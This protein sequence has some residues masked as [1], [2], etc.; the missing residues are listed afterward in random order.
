MALPGEDLL[1]DAIDMHNHPL[2]EG[3][4]AVPLLYETALGMKEAGMA[5]V[6][7]K[8]HFTPTTLPATLLDDLIE[9]FRVFGGVILE[10]SAG[11]IN[12]SVVAEQIRDGAKKFWMPLMTESFW[13]KQLE[14]PRGYLGRDAMAAMEQRHGP[15]WR[16]L[17]ERGELR[18]ALKDDL[19]DVLDIIAANDVIFDT[20]HASPEEALVLVEEAVN[21]G[22]EKVVVD[23]PLSITCGA[24]I[25]QQVE[26][27]DMGAYIEQSW[28]KLQPTG[29]G[30]DPA[31]Y[32]EAIKAV[33]PDRTVLVT[34]YAAGSH[35]PP[36]E[37]MREYI[38][39]MQEYGISES[40]IGVMINDNP[41]DLID[42]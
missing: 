5:G 29:G 42:L 4:L 33:G 9:E 34:D 10:H 3:K 14:H 11:G 36:S 38:V 39:L 7:F 19:R 25:E 35:P 8:P 26:M 30:V 24:S 13:E 12:P 32:A 20:G 28:A 15:F 31:K 17:N 37:A 1:N 40:D 16:Y 41:R 6:L 27:A 23:H 22:V 21:A 18:D 2:G